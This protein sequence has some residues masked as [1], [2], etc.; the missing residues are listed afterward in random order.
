MSVY[1]EFVKGV[2][3]GDMFQCNGEVG[4]NVTGGNGDF[5]NYCIFNRATD[6]EI[7]CNKDARC[8]GYVNDG[9]K[10]QLVRTKIVQNNNQ[11]AV[12][13]IKG[14]INT[15]PSAPHIFPSQPM[16]LPVKT[17]SCYN[18]TDVDKANLDKGYTQQEVCASIPGGVFTGG[19]NMFH[20]GCGT[21]WCCKQ[22]GVT[23]STPLRPKVPWPI[24]QPIDQPIDQP[25]FRPIKPSANVTKN[26]QL[27]HG[28]GKIKD[29][30]GFYSCSNNNKEY[31]M[32]DKSAPKLCLYENEKEMRQDCLTNSDCNSYSIL[33]SSVYRKN[34]EPLENAKVYMTMQNR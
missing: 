4:R 5:N 26:A 2:W 33:D 28:L 14:N 18:Y 6:A 11:N 15:T 8:V 3:A 30:F 10:F 29:N 22:T 9:S 21:C 24:I 27:L 20:P 23:T 17:S 34:G 16:P 13:K 7:A 31:I 1:A 32:G 19:K 12:F 25:I